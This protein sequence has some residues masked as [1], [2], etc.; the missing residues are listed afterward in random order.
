M[1]TKLWAACLVLFCTLLTSGGQIFLKIGSK[2]ASLSPDLLFNYT[3]MVGFLL[4]GF[5]A[6]LLIIDLRGSELS[7]LYPFIATSFIW[8]NLLS[9]HFLGEK[10]NTGGFDARENREL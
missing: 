4:Y 6:I 9:L 10:M 1:T 3:L 7:I 5:R 8:V 2:T